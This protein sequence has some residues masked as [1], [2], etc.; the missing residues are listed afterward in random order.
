MNKLRRI[1]LFLYSTIICSAAVAQTAG[2]HK[3]RLKSGD[4]AVPVMNARKWADSTLISG[5]TKEPTQVLIHFATL[6]TNEQRDSLR[7][8]GITLLDYI[9]D[10]TFSAIIQTAANPLALKSASAYAIIN[11]QPEWKADN[12]LWRKVNSEKG[13][14][15]VLVSFYKVEDAKTIKEL[16]TQMGGQV[17]SGP[18]EEYGAY[19]VNIPANKVRSLAQWYGV[20]YISPLTD[21]VPLD[22][23]SRPAV[24]GN[25]AVAPPS[26]GGYGLTGDSVTVG[27]GDNAS[28]IYHIDLV[29][30]ITNFNPGP[31]AAHGEHVNGIVGGAAIVDPLAASMAPR[32]LLLDYLYDMVLPATGAMY[33]GYNMTITNNSYSVQAA[34]CDYSGT[35]DGY[36]NFV[37]TL[38]IQYPNVLHVFAS[39]NDGWMTC[40]PYP[41]GFATVAGGYQPA[42]NNVVVGSMTD[43][44]VDAYD[45]SRGPI[46]DGRLKPEI[47][48]TGLGAYSTIGRDSYEWAA[49]TSMAS[50][51]VAGG[52]AVLTQHYKHLNGGSQ[53]SAVLLKSILLNGAMDRGNAGPD[54]TYG[55]GTMDVSRSLQIIDNNR[56]N[57]NTIGDGE[58]RTFTFTVPPN[59]A[60][61]KVMLNWFDMP[62]SPSSSVQLVNDLDITVT[63]PS[64]TKHN[65][66][67]PDHAP[68]NVKNAAIEK[69]DHLN[70]SEQVTITNPAAGTYTVTIKGYKIPFGPQSYV[71]SY[72]IIPKPLVMTY[73]LGGEQLSNVDSIR[74]FWNVVTDGS[75]FKLEFSSDN[76]A[77]WSIVD[78][79]IAANERF[80]GFWPGGINSGNCRFRLTKNGTS[81]VVTS[82]RFAI[83]IQPVMKLSLHQCPGYINTHWAP[84][85]NATAY[86]MLKK[87]G[88]GLQVIDMTTDTSYTFKGM[89]VD[90]RSY[91]TVE[92]VINGIP[93][94]RALALTVVANSGDCLGTPS[95]GDL[96]LE[97]VVAP[98]NGRMYTTTQLGSLLQVVV[99][100]RNLYQVPCFNYTIA[101]QLNGGSWQTLTNPG[102]IPAN[103]A[104]TINIPWF[105]FAPP[106]SYALTIAIHND[107]FVD[108]QQV[109]D[110]IKTTILSLPNDTLNLATPFFDG[111]ET[112]SR[113]A[114]QHDSMGVSP[115]GHWDYFN[116]DDS[117]RMRSFVSQDIVI[118][119][120]RSVSL[121]EDRA[122]PYGSHNTFVGTFNL[123]NYDT[124]TTEVRMDFEYLMHGTPKTL[125]GNYVKAR[126]NDT[127]PW[128]PL[129][130]YSATA[131]PGNITKVNSL[132]I[133]DAARAGSLN[134]SSSTQV[135]FGQNDTSLIASTNY[136][137]GI[138]IDN[139][140]LY[141]VANDA[142]LVKVISPM[143]SNCGL[144]ATVPLTV[145]VRNGVNY[146]LY[147]VQLFYR[148][149][150]GLTYAGTIDSIK[151]KASV[152]FTFSQQLNIKPGSSNSLQIWLVSPGDTY[153]PN[154]SILHYTFRNNIVVT[155]FPY[156]ETFDT[157]NGRYFADG[158]NSTWQ[159]GVPTAPKINRAPSGTKVWKTNLSGRY[160]NLEVSYL[161]S[162][163]FD[164]SQLSNP[165]L[166]FSLATDIEDCGKVF[167]DAAYVEY[168][169]DGAT[170]N[171]LGNAGEGTNW[172]DNPFNVWNT[173]GFTRWHVA[174]IPLPRPT[175]GESIRLR[176]VLN[177]DPG[178]T[179]EGIALDDIHIFDREHGIYSGNNRPTTIS[180]DISGNDWHDALESNGLVASVQPN[181]NIGNTAVTLYPHD[182][183]YNPTATQY[184]LSRSYT[185]KTPH[186]PGDS[187]TLRLYLTE[188]EL[189]KTLHDTTCPSCTPVVDAYTLGITQYEN[190]N[191]AGT[192]NGSLADDTGGTFSF[193]PYPTI[194][195][196]PYDN[197]YYAQFKVKDLSEFW[198]NNGGPT[199]KFPAG[200]DYL[201]FL[202]YKNGDEVKN[203]WYSL[204]DTAV[205]TYMLQR[206]E[207]ST[208]FNT[209]MD[210]A[211]VHANPGQYTYNDPVHIDPA[212][213]LYYRL[214]WTMTGKSQVHYS[215]IRKVTS[216][217]DIRAQIKFDARIL[218]PEDVLLTW[219]S[220]IDGMAD[221]YILE[222]SIGDASYAVISDRKA[223]SRYGQQYSMID[224]PG[225]NVE[226]GTPIH[227]KLT[228]VLKDGTRV[229]P[230][231]RTVIWINKNA[232]VNIYPNPNT[233]GNV[234]IAWLATA[235]SVM[236]VHITD[237]IGRTVYDASTVA[238]QWDNL[239]VLKTFSGPKGIYFLNIQI[240]GKQYIAK[241]VY[242]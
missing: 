217:D 21:I 79:A 211:A 9:P 221:H 27:V 150:L 94:Y 50:P 132:S 180:Q 113:F 109:N 11:T 43:L 12:A 191:N 51:Q 117:G 171:K 5:G 138:T 186:S 91:I 238:A 65:P 218:N 130:S 200:V 237:A 53:P 83:N 2:E 220:F 72:D 42:K 18:M 10:N 108:P 63:E 111:F 141:T 204:V 76:G 161:Y 134:F 193:R 68:A 102:M 100:V 165:M 145:Q 59:T 62:G 120:A 75:T 78:A 207:D 15:N 87:V 233:D 189:V 77:S 90:Q 125:E 188:N 203:Y 140:R 181:Q 147:N 201:N 169:F 3:I 137:N 152:N 61:I 48:A 64:G 162:P 149:N 73:P 216:A 158:I 45:E 234:N 119:G 112:M 1:A 6:P 30:R 46:R 126:A 212:K 8:S 228:A 160:K 154:D 163:C 166:S 99:K 115:N 192:E 223:E 101:Y 4:I 210:T 34:D 7:Q 175:G 81:E 151:A 168:S 103:N 139:F 122:V 170:W 89:P 41:Q 222:R 164:I 23:Q 172:Y 124:A 206:A 195:W 157:S 28:G 32:V 96:M 128:I 60:Q 185:I 98:Q 54:F 242:E 104:T 80:K 198:F 19:K 179:F 196:V 232:I 20:R 229:V 69:E 88:Y 39:G 129:F 225:S 174:S 239:T 226:A 202:A 40:P 197:G 49:G 29:D 86:R 36:S 105:N 26:Q 135:S 182:T 24:K 142:Q 209:I 156:L 205:A 131:Y 153:R 194:K 208:D 56:Y 155:S 144:P 123:V 37:D 121:D 110:T 219:Q 177:A 215:P 159:W 33:Q 231:E 57:S 178:V 25:I 67:V 116:D 106:G 84:V 107:D 127:S 190:A 13:S 224:K 74:V 71:T 214:Q 47:L 35:Y 55:F 31:L 66:L 22:L 133:T 52:V 148:L 16:I 235:G 187:V 241:L 227:Y 44:L 58:T 70:N 183:L 82:G 92:P 199:G 95:Q 17:T 240:E 93:G 14:I 97:K 38:A 118:A 143:Q 167:C 184:T 136:G 146:T 176:F 236:K 213:P 114:V 85:P 173:Q 230:N